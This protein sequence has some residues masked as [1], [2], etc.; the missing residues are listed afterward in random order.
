MLVMMDRLDR[1]ADRVRR[2]NVG[3]LYR[4][5]DVVFGGSNHGELSNM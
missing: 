1:V 5:N 3:S 2:G 4:M